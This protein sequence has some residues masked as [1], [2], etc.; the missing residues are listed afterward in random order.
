[1]GKRKKKDT[2]L[3][4][5]LGKFLSWPV[6]LGILVV[7]MAVTAVISNPGAW[8]LVLVLTAV[9]F[10]VALYFYIFKRPLIMKE[11]LNFAVDHAQIQRKLLDELDVPYAL[12]DEQGK[13]LWSNSALA[14]IAKKDKLSKR[15]IWDLF[16]EVDRQPIPDGEH[17][18]VYD[19]E[20]NDSCYRLKMQN[21]YTTGDDIGGPDSEEPAGE[22]SAKIGLIAAYLFDETD[23]VR[24]KLEIENQKLIAGLIYIDNYDEAIETIEDIRSSLLIALIDRKINKYISS[25]GGIVKKLEKDKYFVAIQSRYLET[26]TDTR[27]PLLEDVKTVNI[28]NDMAFTISIGLGL[29]GSSYEENYEFARIAIDMALGRGGDQAVVKNGKEIN[30]YGG[31]SRSQEKSTRVKARVKAHALRELLETRESVFIMGHRFGD[32]DSLGSAV[33][34]YRIC[35][36]LGKTAHIVINDV[37]ASVRPLIDRFK[38]NPDFPDDMFINGDKAQE[39]ADRNAILI[40]VDVNRPGML[41]CRELLDLIPTVVVMDHHRQSRDSIT[42]AVLS[43]VEPYASSACEMVAEVLQYIT[44]N[45]KITQVEADAM[46]AGIVI[47]TNNFMNKTGVRT[48]EAAAFLRRNGADV[49]RVRKMFRDNMQD[50][51]AKAEVVR[52]AEIYEDSFAISSFNGDSIENPTII[53]AQA[54]NE[55]LSIEGIKASVVVTK[56]NDVIY[57]SARSID[58]VNVQVIMEKLGGGGHMSVA[59][60]QLRGCTLEEGLQQVKDVISKMLADGEL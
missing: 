52:Q 14:E 60:A 37:S 54:A 22:G 35:R 46:Y 5:W 55:L 45:I 18:A 53:G 23:K 10:A 13:I 26:L 7:I 47:D 58:E 15:R 29:G 56:Y 33:G 17:E 31:K 24:Y 43:Y 49:T 36:E 57:V 6:Y 16:P 19:I 39:L 2:D 48:F 32:A 41:E 28:G 21:I 42:G 11:V 4:G 59:G 34:I 38:Q 51:K 20:Y 1:M 40:I 8:L 30:Y 44:D 3:G 27:F 50:Y 9:Y 12:L 25:M